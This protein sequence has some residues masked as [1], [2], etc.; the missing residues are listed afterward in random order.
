MEGELILR[1]FV[2][3]VL[4]GL[5]GFEREYRSKEAGLRTHFLVAL[6]SALFMIISQYG[7]QGV[8][9]GR[10]DVARV[11]AQVVTGIGFIGAGVIIFQKNSLRGLT[12]AAGLWVTAAI[13]LGCGGGMY[14]ISTVATVLVLLVLEVM[15][16]FLPQFGEKSL[17][18]TVVAGSKEALM[19]VIDALKER[20][21]SVRSYSVSRIDNGKMRA[22]LDLKVRH[23]N[24]FTTMG[25]LLGDLPGVELESIE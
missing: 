2:A 18:V 3:G 16:Y 24:Y 6:G 19:G 7:F 17:A 8:Q 15:H 10:F 5:I 12:T 11:A 20:K 9:A 14:I 21:I 25:D 22:I 13:G 4:G 1:I 23:D